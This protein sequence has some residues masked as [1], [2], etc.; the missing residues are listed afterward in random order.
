MICCICHLEPQS[1]SHSHIGHTHKQAGTA[2]H[3]T[4]CYYK[5]SIGDRK[6]MAFAGYVRVSMWLYCNTL[7]IRPLKMYYSLCKGKHGVWRQPRQALRWER[8]WFLFWAC[9]WLQGRLRERCGAAMVGKLYQHGGRSKLMLTRGETD[10]YKGWIIQRLFT[11]LHR[12]GESCYE[13][14]VRRLMRIFLSLNF[15]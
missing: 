13:Y 1:H 10:K 12:N 14:G 4:E 15:V 2:R 8:S 9:L 7:H 5:V 3:N 11:R 6:C